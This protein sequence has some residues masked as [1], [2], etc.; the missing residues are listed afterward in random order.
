MQ[1]RALAIGL[2]RDIAWAGFLVRS[3]RDDLTMHRFFFVPSMSASGRLLAV[4][5][6]KNN[7]I[8]RPLTSA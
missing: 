7:S 8:Q 4:A 2:Y 6:S 3:W 5:G 1:R